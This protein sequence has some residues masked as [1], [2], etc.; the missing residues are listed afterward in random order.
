MKMGLLDYRL[1]T[2]Y[3]C[4]VDARTC[5]GV[6]GKMRTQQQDRL[7][8]PQSKDLQDESRV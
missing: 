5:D 4:R 1:L 7:L 2:Q 3:S 6:S 8:T